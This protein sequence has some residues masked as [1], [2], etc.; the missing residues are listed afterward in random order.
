MNLLFLMVVTTDGRTRTD[1]VDV[2]GPKLL[3]TMGC[4]K[5]GEKFALTCLLWVNKQQ[6]NYPITTQ[7][8]ISG[9]VHHYHH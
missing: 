4:V 6:I 7:V 5:L 9:P 3:L 2:L 8:I 1:E